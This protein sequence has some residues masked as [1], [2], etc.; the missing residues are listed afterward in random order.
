GRIGRAMCATGRG[1]EGLSLVEDAASYL[2]AHAGLDRWTG[3]LVAVATAQLYAGRPDDALSTLDRAGEYVGSCPDPYAAAHIAVQKAQ[4]LGALGRMEDAR[5]AAE[6]AVAVSRRC[7]FA[8]GIA[9]ASMMA[10]FAAEQ[11][12][13]GEG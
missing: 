9:H 5:A 2:L 1:T 13:D 12:G 7:D 6:E 4:C 3:A 10:G 8:D 11:L